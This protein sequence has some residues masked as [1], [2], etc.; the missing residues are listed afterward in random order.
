MEKVI[1]T[2]R[3]RADDGTIYMVNE[4]QKYVRHQ[5]LEGESPWLPGSRR[6]AL[7]D[8]SHVNKI[9]DNTFQIFAAETVIRRA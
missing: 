5:M 9:D 8:G 2:H 4:V 6:L 3:M 1:A 7:P